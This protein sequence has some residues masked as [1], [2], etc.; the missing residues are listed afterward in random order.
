M[1]ARTICER[2]SAMRRQGNI[3]MWGF[4]MAPISS[5]MRQRY[6]H[7][8]QTTLDLLYGNPVDPPIVVD[9]LSELKGMFNRCVRKDQWD[10]AMVHEELGAPAETDTRRIVGHLINLRRG[11][12]V[13]NQETVEDAQHRLENTNILLYLENYQNRNARRDDADD[14]GWIYVLSTREAPSIL[15]IGMTSRSVSMRVKE[16][17]SATGVIYPFGARYVFRVNN[18]K[19]AEA[20]IHQS[21][22]DYRIRSDR[23]F[24][25][26]QP[27]EAFRLIRQCLDRLQL[28]YRTKGVMVWFDHAKYYGFV[29][30]DRQGDVFV[31]GS[32]VNRDELAMLTPGAAVEFELNRSRQ[33]SYATR[34]AV[35]RANDHTAD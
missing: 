21:L 20:T 7:A 33:G 29:S 24:F 14:A 22:S 30:A 26:I 1:S 35:V 11:L 13:R 18:V 15:K 34:M 9:A 23:E 12:V 8:V 6:D 27:G 4:G 16:I 31:H 3:A 25:D 10:Y 2:A 19:E 32:E 5:R 17:N 28:R